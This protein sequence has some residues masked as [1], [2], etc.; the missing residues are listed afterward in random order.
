MGKQL[1]DLSKAEVFEYIKWLEDSAEKKMI[2][3]DEL[4]I[5]LRYEATQFFGPEE[6]V[7]DDVPL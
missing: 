7:E 3:L 6:K 1:R 2:V 5:E 4:V